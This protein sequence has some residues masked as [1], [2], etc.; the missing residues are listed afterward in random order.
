MHV[1]IEAVTSDGY[2]MQ[3]GT[4]VVGMYLFTMLLIPALL[5]GVA[6]SPDSHS[7]VVTTSSALGRLYW[8]SFKDGAARRKM[9]PT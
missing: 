1:P 6:T 9:A 2:N 5:A 8:E 4:N 7:R 3:F